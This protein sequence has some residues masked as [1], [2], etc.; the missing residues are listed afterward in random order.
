MGECCR[1]Q[2]RLLVIVAG[3]VV[4]T[5]V[6]WFVLSS[7][8]SS[9]VELVQSAKRAGVQNHMVASPLEFLIDDFVPARAVVQ[10][11]ASGPGEMV[12]DQL[13]EC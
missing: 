10:L 6:C 8:P 7:W 1:V 5:V 4:G 12:R 11:E 9:A 13:P 3:P 2:S